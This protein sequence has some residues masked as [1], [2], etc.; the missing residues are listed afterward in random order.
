MAPAW[1]GS[2]YSTHITVGAEAN[3]AIEDR[4]RIILYDANAVR[5]GGR[6]V[7]RLIQG[8][9][10][11]AHLWFK[12]PL[13]DKLGIYLHDLDEGSWSAL[14]S[15]VVYFRERGFS[16]V[17]IDQFL[18]TEGR[19]VYLSCDDNFRAWYLALDIFADLDVPCTFYVNTEPIRDLATEQQITA[20]YRRLGRKNGRGV[21]LS[22]AELKAIANAGHEI[23]SHAHTHR[24]LASLP[25]EA[26]RREIT[27]SKE[28]LEHITGREVVHFAHPYGMRRHFS[29]DLKAVC[30]D[31]GF[32][33]LANATHGMQYAGQTASAIQR[34]EWCL[35]VPLEFNVDNLTIDGRAFERLT[36]RAATASR[37][38]HHK[39]T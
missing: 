22:I 10:R 29:D 21:P 4:R 31:V 11:S 24:E 12:R 13:P 20:F 28:I 3:V 2:A 16:F 5:A 26:A 38:A 37:P 39:T 23:G 14:R 36:G 18:E 15:L 19:V 30:H 6:E 7:K 8:G 9:I 1:R 35:D 25:F 32:R 33:S 17:S 27:I 34:T